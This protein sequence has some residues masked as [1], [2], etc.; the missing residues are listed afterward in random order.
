MILRILLKWTLFTNLCRKEKKVCYLVDL[1]IFLQVFESPSTPSFMH[2]CFRMITVKIEVLVRVIT[3]S[4]IT[5]T[6]STRAIGDRQTQRSRISNLFFE[7]L[8]KIVELGVDVANLLDFSLNVAVVI[9]NHLLGFGL[10]SILDDRPLVKGSNVKEGKFLGVILRDNILDS[11]DNVLANLLVIV[12]LVDNLILVRVDDGVQIIVTDFNDVQTISG[13]IGFQS[14]DLLLETRY[15]PTVK[16]TVS[17]QI[18]S[19]R[20]TITMV[21]NRDGNIFSNIFEPSWAIAKATLVVGRL[22]KIVWLERV[23][24]QVNTKAYLPRE[25]TCC[26]YS[27]YHYQCNYRQ[28]QQSCR[29]WQRQQKQT[30]LRERQQQRVSL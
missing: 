29:Q 14:S 22:S 12:V 13:T 16:F 17:I 15:S 5:N 10:V 2:L 18:V 1:I 25:G 27:H 30:K 20:T 19:C 7:P 26:G 8:M 6:P 11:T 28:R 24:Y 21:F 23:V 4:S 9:V 3:S